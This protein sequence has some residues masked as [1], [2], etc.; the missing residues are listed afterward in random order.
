MNCEQVKDLLSPYLDD[1]LTVQER[2]SVASHLQICE[3][4]CT[5]LTD[6]RRFDALL[7]Q[8]PRFAPLLVQPQEAFSSSQ[9][10]LLCEIQSIQPGTPAKLRR[11]PSSF[12]THLAGTRGHYRCTYHQTTTTPHWIAKTAWKT[13]DQYPNIKL[14]ICLVTIGTSLLSSYYLWSKYRQHPPASE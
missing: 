14:L 11:R 12:P 2:Q 5:I 10:L 1:Q 8:L 4:C 6:Y 3:M 9:S 7:S 13:G